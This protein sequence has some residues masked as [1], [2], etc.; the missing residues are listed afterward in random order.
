M[1]IIFVR[2]NSSGSQEPV[3]MQS[4]GWLYVEFAVA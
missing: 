3:D 1:M 4:V 2:D